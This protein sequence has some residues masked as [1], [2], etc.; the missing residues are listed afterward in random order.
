MFGYP[1]VAFGVFADVGSNAI[2]CVCVC[3]MLS[4]AWP[5][6]LNTIQRVI[7]KQ[8][9]KR[10]VKRLDGYEY[11]Y[12]YYYDIRYCFLRACCVQRDFK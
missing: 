4:R 5:Y 11:M 7:F 3:N 10:L 1:R 9:G 2:G 8:T 6:V 12:K